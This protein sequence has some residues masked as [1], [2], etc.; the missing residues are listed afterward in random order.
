MV[1]G[2]RKFSGY[3]EESA[4]E[5]ARNKVPVGR[6][7][8]SERYC[9]ARHLPVSRRCAY[10]VGQTIVA[11]GGTTSLMS[12]I[13]DFRTESSAR[14][15]LGTSMES[16]SRLAQLR[17]VLASVGKE[18]FL[19]A[20]PDGSRVLQLLHGGRILGIFSAATTAISI[21]PILRSKP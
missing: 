9:K 17:T 2:H 5:D 7:G 13:S 20:S 14:C 3:S 10:I 21:G 4:L 15:G 16:E 8:I 11:D 18:T 1:E 12:L 19:Y 6:P